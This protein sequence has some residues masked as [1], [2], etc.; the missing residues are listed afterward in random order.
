MWTTCLHV[1]VGSG[2][3]VVV[4]VVDVEVVVV[5]VVSITLVGVV[6]DATLLVG[7]DDVVVVVLAPGAIELTVSVQAAAISTTASVRPALASSP[8]GRLMRGLRS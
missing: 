4:L 6:V 3:S 5:E 7:T 2:G 8:L 1:V